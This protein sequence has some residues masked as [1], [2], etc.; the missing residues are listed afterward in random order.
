[1]GWLSYLGVALEMKLD[2]GVG[3]GGSSW[4]VK[5]LGT[6]GAVSLAI[7]RAGFREELQREVT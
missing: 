4:E 2:W 5:R 7:V 1:M 6:R 3:D